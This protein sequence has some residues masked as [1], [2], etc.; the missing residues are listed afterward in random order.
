MR[1]L[2]SI[3]SLLLAGPF[4]LAVQG[5]P[6]Q[7]RPFD[8]SEILHVAYPQWFKT[9]FL[10][11]Q[12]DLEEA[13]ANNKDGLMLL[14]T[15]DGCSYCD[16]FIQVSLGNPELATRVR[17]R[18][19][20][21]GLEIF[22]DSEMT[23]P[24]GAQTVVKHFAK[25]LGAA[26]SPTLVFLGLDGEVLLRR[27]GYQSPQKFEQILNYLSE[28]NQTLSFRDY[29][30]KQEVSQAKDYVLRDDP[31]FAR[32][33]YMLDR[34]RL[35]ASKPLIVLFEKNGCVECAQ[36]HDVVLADKEVRQ[37]LEAFEVV[38]LDMKDKRTPLV[39][40]DG[41]R[42]TPSAWFDQAGLLQTP[43]MLFFDENGNE[44]LRTDALVLNQ[45]MM[46]SLNFVIEQAYLKGWT[47]QRFARSKGAEKRQKQQQ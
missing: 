31:L 36:F 12:S 35:S 10:D 44:V 13:R 20:S 15:T 3:I 47:Y 28:D 14:F 25:G 4:L 6:A 19:D 17:A 41:K 24:D 7:E 8:D 22:D 1:Q 42:D 23:A 11:L 30:L 32:Q 26:F 43:A 38:R 5:L 21:I 27:V 18:Y 29:L 46:N 33:P 9:S 2:I 40:P 34:S 39:R 45:R 37:T 16:R